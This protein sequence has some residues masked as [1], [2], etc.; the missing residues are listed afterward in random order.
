LNLCSGLPRKNDSPLPRKPCGGPEYKPC[1][2]DLP[3]NDHFPRVCF[4]GPRDT[5]PPHGGKVSFFRATLFLN[6]PTLGFSCP[7]TKRACNRNRFS[8]RINVP[9]KGPQ[10]PESPVR[11]FRVVGNAP[12]F[13]QFLSS[14]AICGP[15][16]PVLFR[17]Y[18][19]SANHPNPTPAANRRQQN[20]NLLRSANFFK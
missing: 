14:W 15:C 6:A 20:S 9:P 8:G 11:R 19:P 4:F 17:N 2:L 16:A 10:V 7:R 13:P 1:L 3:V 5:S 18:P 12:H